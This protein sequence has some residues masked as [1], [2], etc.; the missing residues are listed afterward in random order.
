MR[1]AAVRHF[2]TDVAASTEWY[3]QLLG[4]DPTAG[5]PAAGCV[6]FDVGAD[7]VLETAGDDSEIPAAELIGR[8]TGVSFMVD[9]SAATMHAF[10]A[11]VDVVG[12]PELRSWGG[13]PAT[14]ADPTA[15]S[16][17]SSG[18]RDALVP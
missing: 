14:L 17:N 6:V 8:F 9:D 12:Q 13:T 5:E 11:G 4:A 18:T 1:R 16:S 7:L 3:R 10:D 15:T 2:V